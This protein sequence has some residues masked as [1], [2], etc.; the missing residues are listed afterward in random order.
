MLHNPQ[1]T[2]CDV[3]PFIAVFDVDQPQIIVAL[4]VVRTD[5]LGSTPSC[6][7]HWWHTTGS[8]PFWRG[9]SWP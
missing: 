8:G 5:R 9:S 2:L 3:L 6:S 7:A 4:K 1:L